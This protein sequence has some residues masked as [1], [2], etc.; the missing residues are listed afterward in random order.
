ML[1]YAMIAK[2]TGQHPET[3]KEFLKQDFGTKTLFADRWIPKP[4]HKMDTRRDD[5][6]SRA[7][8]IVGSG[9]PKD[10]DTG[11]GETTEA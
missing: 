2:D 9:I 10:S 5:R 6:A 3:V 8:K 11:A 1:I 7:V 4:T